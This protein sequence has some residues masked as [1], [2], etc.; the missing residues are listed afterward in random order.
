MDVILET[1]EVLQ[2]VDALIQR[3]EL[4]LGN[5]EEELQQSRASLLALTVKEHIVGADS[6]SEEERVRG[7]LEQSRFTAAR[8]QVELYRR[9]LKSLRTAREEWEGE[10]PKSLQSKFEALLSTI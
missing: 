9:R 2:A 6:L 8:K 10:V 4:A 3:S 7:E 5:A 1:D